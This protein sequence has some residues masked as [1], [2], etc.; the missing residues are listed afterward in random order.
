MPTST[1]P[2]A[3]L[4]DIDGTLVD[5]NYVH[6]AAWSRAFVEV[7]VGVAS[8]RVHRSIGM[9][10]SLLIDSLLEG[11]SDDLKERA[12]DLHS[13]YY[14]ESSGQL[15]AFA[16]ARDLVR[17]VAAGEAVVV[18]A[19]SAPEDE[20]T[21]LREVLDVDEHVSAVTSSEDVGTA[22]P[23]PDIVAVALEKAGVEAD[24]AVFIGD[25]I[26]D[27]KACVEAG[28]RFVGVRSGGVSEAELRDAGA[29]AV[30]DDVADLLDRLD[31]SPLANI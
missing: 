19:T 12:Q 1:P 3:V 2:R 10:G 30:Y 26:W 24:A 14:R 7:G 23:R 15:A 22:K 21:T 5:S 13:K 8:W 4:F 9:D 11:E 20:L 25:T 17:R 16:G 27:A 31:E 29:A 18:L 28:V 6:I